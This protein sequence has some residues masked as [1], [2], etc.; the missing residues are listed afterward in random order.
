MR[1]F[2]DRPV[3]SGIYLPSITEFRL[4]DRL[5]DFCYFIFIITIYYGFSGREGRG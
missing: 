3:G 2:D 4:I 1:E 5:I